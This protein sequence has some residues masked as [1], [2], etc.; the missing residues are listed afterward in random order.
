M[1]VRFTYAFWRLC[2]WSH[3]INVELDPTDINV[4]FGAHRGARLY[5]R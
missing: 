1:E 5:D 2:A 3:A 4:G